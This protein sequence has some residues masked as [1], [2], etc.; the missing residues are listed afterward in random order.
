MLKPDPQLGLALPLPA[1]LHSVIPSLGA[2]TSI[3][4]S[5]HPRHCEPK[6]WQPLAELHF[7]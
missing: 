3:I 5:V 7:A 1:Y 6:A 4:A 2:Y